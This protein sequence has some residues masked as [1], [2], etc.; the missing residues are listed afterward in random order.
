MIHFPEA[1]TVHRRMPKEAFYQR[2]NLTAA[3]K[4]KF[5]SDVDRIFVENSLTKENLHLTADSDV[6]EI[7]LL[8]VSLKKPDFDGKVVEAIA[9]QNQHKLL[10]LLTFEDRAQLALYQGKLYR[11]SWQ[12]ASEMKLEAHGQSLQQI[13]DGFIEQIALTEEQPGDVSD[14]SVDER[15]KRLDRK[16]KMEKQ[17]VS[18]QQ[19]LR[20][21][22]Q[23]N[24]QVQLNAAL[25]KLK[26]ELEV[27]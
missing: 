16:K 7:L 5:V 24:K 6:K 17:I 25:K 19:K 20:K 4:D 13:W 8:L 27:L 2:L 26:K 12:L 1:T 3:L 9:R 22:K 11:S 21:E 10:F 18:L 15:L 23:L 14:L